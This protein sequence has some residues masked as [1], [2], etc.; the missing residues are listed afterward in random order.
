MGTQQTELPGYVSAAAA[1]FA[2][3]VYRRS[4]EPD[5]NLTVRSR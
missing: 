5:L 2:F 1:E 4:E 3:V